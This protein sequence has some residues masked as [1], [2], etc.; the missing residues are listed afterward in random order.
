[1]TEKLSYKW[2]PI[3]DLPVN[4]N[5]LASP[6][7]DAL[8]QVWGEQKDQLGQLDSLRVFNERLK[9]KW[10]IE[11]GIIEQLYT[12]DR[13]ITRLLVERGINASLIPHGSTNRPPELVAAMIH[14]HEEAFDWLFDFIKGNR[15]PTTSF[16]REL[17]A[18]LTRHQETSAG[19]NGQGRHVEVQLLRGEWKRLPNNPT[20]QDGALHEYCPPEH[21]ASE[22]DTLVRLW[23]D[24]QDKNVPIQVEAAWLHHRF[25]QTHPFQDGNGRV[26][27]SLASLTFL[28]AGWFPL[29]ITRDDREEYIDA[30]EKADEGDLFVLVKLFERFQRKAFVEALGVAAEF[31]KQYQIRHVIDSAVERLR[32]RDEALRLEWQQVKDIAKRLQNLTR[33]RFQGIADQVEEKM[34]HVSRAHDTRVDSESDEGSRRHYFRRQVIETAKRLDYY[35]DLGTYHSW[36]RLI[37][38][39]DSQMELL[40][41]FHGIGHEFRG[42]LAC[43]ACFFRR[44]VTEEHEREIAD[45]TPI[46]KELFQINYKETYQQ[47]QMR[48]EEWLNQATVIGLD[49]WR[50]AL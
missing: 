25:T 44:E 34:S 12:I 14:D 27:R 40:L 11:T 15:P 48:F 47:V 39:T 18:L 1:M 26:A 16:I 4:L 10:A 28:R 21:V 49:L 17:H 37:L 43:S 20:R 3:E 35:A 19:V 8:A 33:E 13:G 41:S 42:I 46:C 32:M 24:C 23:R 30:L 50:N 36:A 5:G 22:M 31:Q 6:E 2:R 7:M 38:R 9:R 45:I 29:V